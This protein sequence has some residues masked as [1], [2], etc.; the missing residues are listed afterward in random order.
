MGVSHSFGE[1]KD[2]TMRMCVDYRGLNSV[3]IKNKYPLPRVDEL[4]D[5][6]QGACYFSKIDLRSGYQQ[7]RSRLAGIPK[8][9]FRTR[10]GHYEFLVM[11]FGLTN[12]PATFMTLLD[13]VL[14]PYLVISSQSDIGEETDFSQPVHAMEMLCMQA[15]SDQETCLSKPICD[16]YI[17]LECT[18]DAD[19]EEIAYV[20]LDKDTGDDVD[21]FDADPYV[22]DVNSWK[23]YDYGDAYSK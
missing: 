1:E 23:G 17:H 19:H 9:A 4:F 22:F 13:S 11:P 7:V 2:G 18:L 6:L 5:Q 21:A 12:A 14:H 3:T 20:A 15:N 16:V 10:F 8:T